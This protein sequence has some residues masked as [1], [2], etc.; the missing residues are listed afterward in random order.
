MPSRP[1]RTST[2]SITPP[3]T[4]KRNVRLTFGKKLISAFSAQVLLLALTSALLGGLG[5][6]ERLRRA[7]EEDF[8]RAPA[9]M[10]Q[11]LQRNFQRFKSEVGLWAEDPRYAAWLGR[12]SGLD[13]ADHAPRPD[14]LRAAHDGL[15]ALVL[16]SWD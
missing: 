4:T 14:D 15:G 16:T 12:A 8:Q 10:R 6:R 11:E 9:L 1:T 13:A 7:I 5:A 2:E 3:A